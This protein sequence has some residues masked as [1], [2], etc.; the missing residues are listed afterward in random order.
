MFETFEACFRALLDDPEKDNTR[1]GTVTMD[2]GAYEYYL[3][4]DPVPDEATEYVGLYPSSDPSRKWTVFFHGGPAAEAEY[5]AFI[6]NPENGD[7]IPD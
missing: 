6:T 7:L 5:H 2:D 1:G 3:N 4:H